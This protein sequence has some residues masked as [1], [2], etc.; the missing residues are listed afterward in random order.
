MTTLHGP[1][2]PADD[3]QE[4][5]VLRTVRSDFEAETIA[6]AL[7]DR[8]IDARAVGGETAGYRAAAPGAVRVMV[9]RLDLERAEQALLDIRTG[10]VDIAWDELNPGPPE[11]AAEPEPAASDSRRWA[12]TAALAFLLPAGLFLTFTFSGPN[13]SREIRAIG[14]IVVGVALVIIA[15]LLLFRAPDDAEVERVERRRHE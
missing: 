7:R 14:P 8:G 15:A 5:V 9:R 2:P 3:P 10:S 13:Y 11:D 12:W 4:P 6:A 1:P